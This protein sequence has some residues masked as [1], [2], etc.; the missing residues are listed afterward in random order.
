[1][2][3]GFNK[4]KRSKAGNNKSIKLTK[5]VLISYIELIFHVLVTNH[6]EAPL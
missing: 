6:I 3:Y 5:F 1:M 4:K 2:A